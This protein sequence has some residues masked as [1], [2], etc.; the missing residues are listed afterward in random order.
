MKA[1][2]KLDLDAL[3][4]RWPAPAHDDLAWNE[5]A[6]GIVAAALA[7]KSSGLDAALFDA[8]PLAMEAGEP[9]AQRESS[10]GLR[11][12]SGERKMSDD[13]NQGGSRD[14]SVPSE[15]PKRKQSLKEIAARASQSGRA[16]VPSVPPSSGPISTPPRS[17]TTRSLALPPRPPPPLGQWK[18]SPTTP[19]WSISKSSRRPLRR[20]RLPLPPR[21]SRARKACSTTSPLR[22]RSR[23]H[24][25]KK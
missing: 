20:S 12:S 8:V 1:D 11:A 10:P 6:D 15:A 19:G 25:L 14:S 17:S 23:S 5:R 16:S 3:L 7:A 21:P 22:R 4:A 2:D 13:S 18:R 24:M 9:Q